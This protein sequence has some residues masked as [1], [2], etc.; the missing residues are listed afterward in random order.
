MYE[1]AAGED[2]LNRD[3]DARQMCCRSL[4]LTN[5]IISAAGL[6]DPQIQG[7]RLCGRI[8][9]GIRNMLLKGHVEP[10]IALLTFL[11]N[12]SVIMRHGWQEELEKE[13]SDEPREQVRVFLWKVRSV[14][15]VILVREALLDAL[16][17]IDFSDRS[18][19]NIRKSGVFQTL[20][21]VKAAKAAN[22]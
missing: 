20:L 4:Q 12:D 19:E 2:E 3:T 5:F 9:R 17:G 6:A 22:S 21:L 15:P 7:V 11:A 13:L 18:E 8:A 10:V 16:K 1:T 14:L